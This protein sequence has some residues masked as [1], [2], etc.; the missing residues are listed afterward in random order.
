MIQQFQLKS[1]TNTKNY[2][3]LR[4]KMKKTLLI[5][6]DSEPRYATPNLYSCNTYMVNSFAQVFSSQANKKTNY[7][8]T[9]RQTKKYKP[10]ETSV[11]HNTP[12]QSPSVRKHS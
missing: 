7:T 6:S 2:Y 11:F 12:T 3:E 10:I 9:H 8:F 4:R 1:E 5:F